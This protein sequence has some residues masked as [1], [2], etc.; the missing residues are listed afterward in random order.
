M[1]RLI[2]TK[3][4]FLLV[5][6]F[7]SSTLMVDLLACWAKASKSSADLLFFSTVSSVRA[8]TTSGE[9]SRPSSVFSLEQISDTVKPTAAL[10]S[11][12]I[13]VIKK[14]GQRCLSQ[15]LREYFSDKIIFGARVERTPVRRTGNCTATTQNQWEHSFLIILTLTEIVGQIFKK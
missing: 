4:A 14:S 6:S 11:C 3:A 1:D 12:S 8:A 13:D 10:N 5:S 15:Y 2:V 7:T 9:K